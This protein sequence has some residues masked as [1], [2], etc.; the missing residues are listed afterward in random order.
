[1]Q[2]NVDG[3]INIGVLIV[4]VGYFFRFEHRVAELQSEFEHRLTRVET[5]LD[6]LLNGQK[7]NAAELKDSIKKLAH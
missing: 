2:F 1:M 7:A 4:V 5:K 6:V 3:L